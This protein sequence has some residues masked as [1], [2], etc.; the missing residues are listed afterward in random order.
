MCL[1][2]VAESFVFFVPGDQRGLTADQFSN[3]F[4]VNGCSMTGSWIRTWASSG[5]VAADP[6]GWNPSNRRHQAARVDA[7]RIN[8][9]E[10][11]PWH[12][13]HNAHVR[14]VRR[15]VLRP[16][17]AQPGRIG[18]KNQSLPSRTNARNL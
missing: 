3:R 8:W 2:K 4:P 16:G 13:E 9:W 1:L 7:I 17:L 10:S 15:S 18:S 5:D 14:K 11:D 12:E 6:T